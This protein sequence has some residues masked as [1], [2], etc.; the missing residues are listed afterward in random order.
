MRG[1]RFYSCRNNSHTQK[2]H[3]G[4]PSVSTL[5]PISHYVSGRIAISANVP[6][7]IRIIAFW[8]LYAS[9][10]KPCKQCGIGR[11]EIL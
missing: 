5:E 1:R 8:G 7:G 2:P 10:D 9:V 11:E 6:I 3:K 4:R